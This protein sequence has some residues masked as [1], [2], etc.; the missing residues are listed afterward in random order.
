MPRIIDKENKQSL[1]SLGTSLMSALLNMCIGFFISPV[2][3][4][5]LGVEANGFAQLANNFVSYASLLTIAINAMAGRFTTI[6]YHRGEKEKAEKYYTSA[7]VGN[8]LS[9]AVLI[10]PAIVLIFN[11]GSVVRIQTTTITDVQ[12][13]FSLTFLSFFSSNIQSVLNISTTVKNKQYLSNTMIM[14]GAVTRIAILLIL[15]N[16]FEIQLY[17]ISL[18]AWIVSIL[19]VAGYYGI[20]QRL[21]PEIHFDMVNFDLTAMKEMLGSGTWSVVNKCGNLLMTGF[22]L[23]L[24]N[25]LIGS[26]EMG[27]LSVAKT[28]PTNIISIAATLSWNWNPKMTKEYANNDIPQM[29]KTVDLSAK[30]SSIII[31]VPTMTFCVFAP[32]FYSLWMPTQD[33]VVLSILSFLSLTAYTILVG[34]SSVYNIFSITNKLKFNSLTYVGGAVVSIVVSIICVKYTSL[35]IYA[36]AGISSIIVIIRNLIFLLPYAAKTIGL[37][38]YTFYKYVLFDGACSII[39]AAVAFVVK[40]FIPMDSWIMFLLSCCLVGVISMFLLCL[41][42]MKNEQ[43]RAFINGFK[44][45][46]K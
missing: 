14:I 18:A 39:V 8:L 38:W 45:Q 43:R 26:V 13:L 9:I 1:I 35:G 7:M 25:I 32:Q 2:I 28:I 20:K 27:V 6:A 41:I 17:Y 46:A 3:V 15:F 10:V 29:L 21:L 5:D 42:M 23:L 24:T 16:F 30:V 11:I 33:P 31:S 40:L 12:I 19:L 4:R 22:D 44:K 34:T 36:V 37:K